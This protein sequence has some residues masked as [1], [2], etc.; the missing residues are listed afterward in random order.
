MKELIRMLETKEQQIKADKVV[1]LLKKQIMEKNLYGWRWYI[2][3]VIVKIVHHMIKTE[4]KLTIAVYVRA[5]MQRAIT[6]LRY[7]TCAKRRGNYE[8]VSLDDVQVGDDSME[9]EMD[10]AQRQNELYIKIMLNYGKEL[11]EQLK[12]IIYAEETRLEKKVL[13]KVRTEE[14]REFLKDASTYY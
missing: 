5:G 3:D 1:N 14:F 9:E 4:F 12:P 6:Q 13:R 11:A 8:L 7:A 10:T 2:D